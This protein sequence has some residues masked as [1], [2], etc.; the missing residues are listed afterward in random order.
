VSIARARQ[1]K[2]EI[3]FFCW[4]DSEFNIPLE[5]VIVSS[6]FIVETPIP[7]VKS[8]ACQAKR[9]GIGKLNNPAQRRV[10]RLKLHKRSE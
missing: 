7:K 9:S 6:S 4:F 10:M 2:I 3:K 8:G 5:I 1:I